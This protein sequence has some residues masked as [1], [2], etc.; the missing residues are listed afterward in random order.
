VVALTSV[1]SAYVIKDPSQLGNDKDGEPEGHQSKR[2]RQ[3]LDA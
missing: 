3:D 1:G 2:F